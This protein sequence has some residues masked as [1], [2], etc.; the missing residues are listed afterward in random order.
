MSPEEHAAAIVAALA[1]LPEDRDP[2]P[3]PSTVLMVA[4]RHAL[5]HVSDFA[6]LGE[7]GLWRVV[8]S[9]AGRVRWR[10]DVG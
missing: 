3:V 5:G 1:A 10:S 8:D 4:I 9:V 7:A 6:E 2:V